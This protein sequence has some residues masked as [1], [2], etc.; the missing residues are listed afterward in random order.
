ML[1]ATNGKE[2]CPVEL[3]HWWPGREFGRRNLDLFFELAAREGTRY[4]TVAS[5]VVGEE[6]I[7]SLAHC[8]E[9]DQPSRARG[10]TI[11]LGRLN[12]QLKEIGYWLECQ[13]KG[14]GE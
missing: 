11:A 3:I 6:M 9:L 13:E 1:V 5:V 2:S 7:L 14:A 12:K 10:R 8:C 4:I